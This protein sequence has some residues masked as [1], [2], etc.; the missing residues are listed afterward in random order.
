M[1]RIIR[2]GIGL[3]L[4]IVPLM[5]EVRLARSRWSVGVLEDGDGS[6]E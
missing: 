3:V 1:G 5:P 4:S 6:Y 2:L